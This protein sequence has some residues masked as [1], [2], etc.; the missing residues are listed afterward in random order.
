MTLGEMLDNARLYGTVA[1]FRDVVIDGA[2]EFFCDANELRGLAIGDGS[3]E[4]LLEC[5]VMSLFAKTLDDGQVVLG[6]GLDWE[7]D[8]YV[9]TT[10]GR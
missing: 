6:I 1:V 8:E 3:D 10:A 2:E 5:E 7:G 9:W 4:N